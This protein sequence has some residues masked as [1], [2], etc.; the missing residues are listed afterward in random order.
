MPIEAALPRN[1]APDRPPPARFDDRAWSAGWV[2]DCP[3]GLAGGTIAVGGL[4]ATRT[5]VLVRYELS[6]GKGEAMRLAPGASAFVVPAAPGTREVLAS[7]GALGIDHILQG[8]DHLLFV[9]ALL[10][11]ADGRRL[12]G[13]VTAFTLAH[14]LS[15]AAAAPGWIVAPAPPVEAVVALSIAFLAAELV[16]PEAVRDRLAARWPRIVAFGFGLLHGLG[17]AWALLEVGLPAGNVP[18]ALLAFNVGVEIGQ[19]MFIAV[20]LLTG[21]LLRRLY[22]QLMALAAAPGSPG[23]RATGYAVG[24]LASFWV[25]RRVAAF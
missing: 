11:I 17:F 15:L 6:P 25:I 2:A 3:G 4:D 18:L 16:K 8:V 24:T 1:C 20:V 21:L 13:A 7:Y 22:P 5:D 10:L 23:L 19:I 9:F 12:I 14:S